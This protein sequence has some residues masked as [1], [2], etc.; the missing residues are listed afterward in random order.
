M[1]KKDINNSAQTIWHILSK[2]I[3]KYMYFSDGTAFVGTPKAQT[4]ASDL[5]ASRSNFSEGTV[6][7]ST[8]C[9][10]NFL[11]TSRSGICLN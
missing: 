3:K 1:V 10:I 7:G 5:A 2:N 6:F 4:R 11:H 8:P 9:E